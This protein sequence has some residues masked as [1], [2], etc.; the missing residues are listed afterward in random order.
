MKLKHLLYVLMLGVV[1]LPILAQTPTP[2]PAEPNTVTGSA[3]IVAARPFEET[4]LADL[5]LPPGFTIAVFAQ[6]LGNIRMIA[7][8]EDGT[9]YLTRREQRD[10][11]A[12]F[13]RDGDGINDQKDPL[14]V[15]SDLSFIHGITI[16]QDQ[17]YLATDT[18]VY[19]ADMLENGELSA[20]APIITDL[21]DGGQHPNRT[22]AFDAD[23]FLYITVGSECN[24]CMPTPETA[25]ILRTNA[26]GSEQVV[27]ASG[28]R[29]TIGF[30]W[31]P[32][33]G[34]MWGMDH[35]TDWRGDNTPPEELN[36]LAQGVHYGW[37]YCYGGQ[38][39]DVFVPADPSAMSKAE[40]CQTTIAPALEYQ[41]HSAPIG[42][43]FYT[44]SQFPAEYQDDAL[45]AM[46]G[47]WNRREAV[48]YKIV[49]LRFDERGQPTAF[50][51]F[52]TGWLIEE[53]RAHFG[54][55]AGLALLPDGSLLISEDTNGILYRVS[56]NG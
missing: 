40:F 41:A 3:L 20:L 30:G 22:L 52:I 4:R 35:G 11:I 34:E 25:V 13:D 12:L 29:N 54:R 50:E 21:P 56:Y 39:V 48:G 45:I 7:V 8:R 10:V 2:P 15:A 19:V 24:A 32:M 17:L 38:Q 9:I 27:F 37:P 42:M 43:I 14:I 33:S 55:V 6:D 23:G 46:R 16:H 36:R 49:R 44:G 31:H 26:D 28:L 5:Q 51:D 1:C 18:H 47:S 53:G